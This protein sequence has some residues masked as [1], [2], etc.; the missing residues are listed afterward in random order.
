VLQDVASSSPIEVNLYNPA[1]RR[2]PGGIWNEEA[3]PVAVW[4]DAEH[5]VVLPKDLQQ[6][7]GIDAPVLRWSAAKRELVLHQRP[8]LRAR[9]ERI[10]ELLAGWKAAGREPGNRG[11]WHVLFSDGRHLNDMI[12]GED[13]TGSWNVVTMYPL[14][15]G[16]MDRL[17]ADWMIKREGK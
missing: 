10:N 3:L 7:L 12:F 8:K 5:R 4:E 14:R 16:Q 11:G 13:Q 2:H 6:A 17:S 9:I 1:A 15:G